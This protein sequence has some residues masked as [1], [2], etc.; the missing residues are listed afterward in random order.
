[1]QKQ[2]KLDCFICKLSLIST[3]NVFAMC[4]KIQ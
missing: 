1:M 4:N 3:V 2:H